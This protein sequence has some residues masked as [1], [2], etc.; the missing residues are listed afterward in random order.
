M[1]STPGGLLLVLA[2]MLPFVGVL[3]G[4]ALGGRAVKWVA[5]A[6]IAAGIV[7]AGATALAYS[8][9]EYGMV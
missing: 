4:F 2:V 1:T 3:A 7:N 6:T 9:E 8:R 5:A